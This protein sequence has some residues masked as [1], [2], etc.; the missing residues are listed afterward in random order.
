MF[1]EKQVI[2]YFDRIF[3][4]L[5]YLWGNTANIANICSHLW[6]NFQQSFPVYLNLGGGNSKVTYHWLS[7]TNASILSWLHNLCTKKLF[8]LSE[9]SWTFRKTALGS[10]AYMFCFFYSFLPLSANWLVKQI[11]NSYLWCVFWICFLPELSGIVL[12]I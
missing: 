10:R 12:E 1:D 2:L 7:F 6:Q 3:L 8:H 11:C 4:Y 9:W 5:Y